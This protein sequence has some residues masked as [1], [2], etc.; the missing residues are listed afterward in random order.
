MNKAISSFKE[1]IE[2]RQC[3][4]APAREHITD[5]SFIVELLD[6]PDN[7]ASQYN[8]LI[9]CY[10]ELLPLVRRV[11]SSVV[12]EIDCLE[13]MGDAFLLMRNFDDA[14]GRYVNTAYL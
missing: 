11:D 4:L 10:E 12:D 6:L 5:D 9:D 13:Q 14:Y 2:I 8:G 1:S 3:L 7:L